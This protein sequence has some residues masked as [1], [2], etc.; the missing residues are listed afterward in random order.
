MGFANAADRSEWVGTEG[1]CEVKG[2]TSAA[3]FI[4]VIFKRK[5]GEIHFGK[6]VGRNGQIFS[7]RNLALRQPPLFLS[8]PPEPQNQM[9]D[10]PTR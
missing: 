3:H 2:T 4:N 1:G 5:S 10:F 7:T 6:N 9:H 8:T